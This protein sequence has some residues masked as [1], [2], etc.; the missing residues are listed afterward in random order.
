MSTE[1]EGLVEYPD[2]KPYNLFQFSIPFG[3]GIKFRVSDHIV[4]AYEIGMRKTFTD[5]LDDVSTRYVDQAI[6]LNERG[7]G[8][9]AMA[10]RGD[11][12]EGINLGLS[13][14]GHRAWQSG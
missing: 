8:A 11:E 14:G 10:F 2:R 1:G 3:G 5:Y 7:P 9:V 12:G 6:L 4:V 13:A